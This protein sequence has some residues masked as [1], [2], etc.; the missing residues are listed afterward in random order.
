MENDTSTIREESQA[1]GESP[2]IGFLD[3]P[4]E[5]RSEIYR[6]LLLSKELIKLKFL[7]GIAPSWGK[8]NDLH[9]TIIYTCHRIYAEARTILYGESVFEI[10]IWRWGEV[11][12][13]NI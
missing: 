1:N 13:L 8:H 4:A 11:C 3:L 2:P 9:P 10:H 7:P 6:Y 12:Y 5:I